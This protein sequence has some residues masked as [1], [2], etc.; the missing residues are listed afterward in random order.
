MRGTIGDGFIVNFIADYIIYLFPFVL[1]YEHFQIFNFNIL[2]LVAGLN[3]LFYSFVLTKLFS[4]TLLDSKGYKPFK[5]TIII[6]YVI[7]SIIL[8]YIIFLIVTSK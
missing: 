8:V 5:L 7:P 6:A 1:V 3:I 2:L 4:K